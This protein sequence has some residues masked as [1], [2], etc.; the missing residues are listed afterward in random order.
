MVLRVGEQTWRTTPI[1]A[2]WEETPCF[3]INS[4][5]KDRLV[6]KLK[7]KRLVSTVT[8]AQYEMNLEEYNLDTTQ[9]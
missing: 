4:L 2:D 6:V 7:N 9:S 1:S 5:Q 8:L 3:L